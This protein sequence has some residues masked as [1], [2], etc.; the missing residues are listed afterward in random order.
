MTQRHISKIPRRRADSHKRDYGHVLVVAG[1]MGMTGA[2][3]L[4]SQAA[5]TSGCG[6]VT[7]AIPQSLNVIAE[8]KLTEVMTLPLPETKDTS[9]SA[10]AQKALLGFSL[11]MNAVALGPGLSRNKETQKLIRVLV[12]KINKPLVLDADGINAFQGYQ[13]ALK[14]R[15]F[16][17]V[18]T[19]HPGEMSRLIKKD[20][21]Y[22]KK[23]R[24]NVA[25]RVSKDYNCVTVLKGHRT[26]VSSPDGEIYVNET[27]N[28]GMSTAGVGDVLT[29]M[30][31]SF[32]AQGIDVYSASVVAVYL[33]GLAGDLAAKELGQF[34]MIASDLLARIPHVLKDVI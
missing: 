10:K 32:I 28:S 7:L 19:P 8:V 29:G 25:K 24:I 31:V 15:R 20:A 18:L 22:I 27:G 2:A 26:V 30:L 9:L 23:N 21:A 5:I 34:G 12:Q 16:P 17:T 14:G 4:S 6:L 3:Y 11:S 33:H 1:S 13:Q